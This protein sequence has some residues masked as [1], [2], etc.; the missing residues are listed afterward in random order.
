MSTIAVTTPEPYYAI[1]NPPLPPVTVLSDV[2]INKKV[3]IDHDEQLK[4]LKSYLALFRDRKSFW[5]EVA[6]LDR[7]HYKNMNQQRPF[8]RFKR[9][10]ELRRI[11]KRLKALEIDREIERLYLSFWNAKA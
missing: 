8:H 5:I 4:M 7:L 9:S 2:R 6:V 1:L 3:E 10:M 11:L